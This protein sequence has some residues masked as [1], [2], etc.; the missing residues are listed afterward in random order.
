MLRFK[1]SSALTL[2]L[3]VFAMTTKSTQLLAQSA[4]Q[5]P[6]HVL[7]HDEAIAATQSCTQRT[8]HFFAQKPAQA[9]EAADA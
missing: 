8:A 3:S 5:L 1:I 6:K 7:I 9:P 2:G 4:A